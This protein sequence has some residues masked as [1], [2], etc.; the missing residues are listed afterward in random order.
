MKPLKLVVE[1][2]NDRHL[3]NSCIFTKSTIIEISVPV[4][5]FCFVFLCCYVD[6]DYEDLVQH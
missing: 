5:L 4:S 1:C 6:G 3:N 2:A